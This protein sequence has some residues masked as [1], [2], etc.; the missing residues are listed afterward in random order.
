MTSP[1]RPIYL[2]AG[3]FRSTLVAFLYFQRGTK[4]ATVCY[5]TQSSEGPF[6]LNLMKWKVQLRSRIT[7]DAS[8]AVK[9][10]KENAETQ[11]RNRRIKERRVKTMEWFKKNERKQASTKSPSTNHSSRWLISL[12]RKPLT[13]VNLSK[14]NIAKFIVWSFFLCS[15]LRVTKLPF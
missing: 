6:L 7:I 5:C 9:S 4:R 10:Q 1:P 8:A 3:V 15:M 2:E 12:S 11:L 14:A 13:A